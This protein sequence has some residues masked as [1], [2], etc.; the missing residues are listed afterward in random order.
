ML[1]IGGGFGT[2]VHLLA[3]NYPNMR[4][5]LYLDIAPNLYVGTQYLRSIFGDSVRTYRDTRGQQALSFS[6]DGEL[7]IICIAPYQLEAFAGR[8]DH[9]HNAH[10]FV[11]MP[12][13]V[14]ANYARLS[15]GILANQGTVSLVSYDRFDDK[16]INPDDLPTYFTFEFIRSLEPTLTP[17]RSD[18]HFVGRR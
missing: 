8:V 1:E 15:E 9:I 4:K 6:S 13:E 12:R 5:F 14:V 16:T 11:E 3:T 18:Y 2:Y 17:S 7:E 10:S